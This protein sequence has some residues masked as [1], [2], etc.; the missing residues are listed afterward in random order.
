MREAGAG[1]NAVHEYTPTGTLVTT[2]PVLGSSPDGL[3]YDSSSCSFW[4]Y[5][6]GTDTVRHYDQ[7]FNELQNFPGTSANGFANG[8]GLAVAGN[9]LYIVA[10]SSDDLVSFDISGQIR[11]CVNV[12][13]P[14][15]GNT[16]TILMVV[17]LLCPGQPQLS[18]RYL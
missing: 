5:D 1:R 18:I 9:T 2:Y 4:L 12:P 15:L 6:S 17:L 7:G 16:S 13:I 10:S 8:E 14:T 11:S 3:T